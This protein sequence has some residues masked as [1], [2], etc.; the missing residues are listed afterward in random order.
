MT[1]DDRREHIR[2][3]PDENALAIIH[4]DG[5]EDNSLI[6]LLRDESHEGCGAVFH[7]EHFPYE[8]GDVVKLK[9]GDLSP[10]SAEITW[11]DSIDKKLVKA[12]FKYR[13]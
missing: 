6:G 5:N 12:G 13:E 8:T 1:S 7:T 9:P 4:I 11:T 2:F 10:M 3:N